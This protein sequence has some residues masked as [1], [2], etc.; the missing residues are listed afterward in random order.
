MKQIWWKSAKQFAWQNFLCMLTNFFTIL[1]TKAN[2]AFAGSSI[3]AFSIF[4]AAVSICTN[5]A[6][7]ECCCLRNTKNINSKGQL[8]PN[9]STMVEIASICFKSCCL[10]KFLMYAYFWGK[11]ARVLLSW[12]IY[13]WAI[14][15]WN[16]F[17]EKAQSS[18]LGKISY[19]CLLLR[20]KLPEGYLVGRYIF[21]LKTYS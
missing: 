13:I 16:K 21:E 3:L 19:V 18:L 20:Q 7:F 4:R 11:N 6:A 2:V 9:R 15:P 14:C 5:C 10:S 8:Y 1:S 17:D 12:S